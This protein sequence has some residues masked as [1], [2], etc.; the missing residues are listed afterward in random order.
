M[1]GGLAGTGRARVLLPPR[2]RGRGAHRGVPRGHAD[3]R[4]TRPTAVGC[5]LDQIVKSLVLVCD[6]R[7]VVV[8]RPGR[9]PR[10]T[11][12]RS[13]AALDA[14]VARV[15]RR[16][17]VEEATGFAPGAVAPFP[18]PKSTTV[19][20]ERALLP[21]SLVWAGAGSSR[22]MVGD[23]PARARAARHERGRWTSSQS[24]PT[25]LLTEGE[26]TRCKR[27]RRSG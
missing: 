14:D 16:H 3:R 8:S 11:R 20:M 10:A 6:E 21:A 4:R 25:I 9:P 27:P 26:L 2:R 24:Q 1:V 18:L 19:L 23:Q 13:L 15:A 17:E 22:H 12:R 5:E 7:P